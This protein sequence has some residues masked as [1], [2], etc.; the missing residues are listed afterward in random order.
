MRQSSAIVRACAVAS[1]ALVMFS[2]LPTPV[3]LAQST[4]PLTPWRGFI[5]H[6]SATQTGGVPTTGVEVANR[7]ISGDGRFVVMQSL[8]QDLVAGDLTWSQDIFLRDR[9]TGTMTRVSVT[10]DGTD[11]DGF[12]E[13]AAISTNGRHVAFVSGATNLVPGDT[14]AT[15]DIFVRDLGRARTVRV[16]VATDGIQSDGSSYMPAISA[17]GRFVAFVSQASTLVPGQPLNAPMQVYLHDRDTDGNGIFDEASRTAT[18]LESVSTTGAVADNYTHHVRVSADGRFVLFESSATNLDAAGNPGASNHI[19]LRDRQAGTTKMIDRAVTGAPSI[20]GA[21]YRTADMS[22]DGRFITYS[23][24]S[25]DIVFMEGTWNSQVLRYDRQAD[26]PRTT[27]VTALPDGTLGNGYTFDTSVSADGRYVAFRSTSTN[28]ASPAQPEN[29]AGVFVR[30]MTTGAF[31]RVDVLNGGE[32]FDHSFPNAVSLSADGTAVAFM[33]NAMNAVDGAYTFGSQHTFVVTAF[34]VSATSASFPTGGGSGAIDVAAL[35]VSGWNA[36]SLDPWIVLT[37]GGG[38]AA[39]SRTVNFAVDSNPSPV[40]RHG[41]IRLGSI[42]VAIQQDG[43]GD[44]TPPVIAPIV[45]G[46]LSPSGWYTSDITVQWSVSDPDSEILGVGPGCVTSSFTSDFL[47]A[48]PTCEATSHGGTASVSVP[49]RRDTTPPSIA[50]SAPAPVY[51]RT[52]TAITPAFSCQDPSGHSGVATCQRTGGSGPLDT[53]TP[54]WHPFTVTAVDQAGNATSKTVEYLIGTGVCVPQAPGLKAWWRFN[55][56]MFDTVGRLQASPSHSGGFYENAVAGKGWTNNSTSNRLVTS[57]GL[58]LLM[59]SALTVS[60]WVKP[61]GFSGQSGTL[62][63]KPAHYRVARYP[64]GTLRWAFSHTTGYD[65]V[66]TGAVI[67]LNLWSHVTVTYDHGLVKSYLN[68]RLV[69]T[70]QLSGTLV[71][72]AH[73]YESLTI[74]GRNDVAATLLGTFDE[75]QIYDRAMGA[76]DVD[77]VARAGS[78][79][80]CVPNGSTLA[81]T[82]PPTIS[83]GSTFRATAVLRDDTGNPVPNRYVSLRSHVSPLGFTG[84]VSGTTNAAGE[85]TADLPVAASAA[86]GVYA[87]AAVAIFEGDAVYRESTGEASATLVGG[88]PAV[89]WPS[90]SAIVYGTPLSTTQLNAT[91]SVAGS[92]SYSPASGSILDAGTHTLGVTFTP[93]DLAHWAPTTAAVT[94]TVNK[95]TP[96]VTVAGGTF[97]Y[98]GQPHAGNGTATGVLGESLSPVQLLYN[99]TSGTPPIDAGAHTVRA[100]FAGSANY[101]A[102]GSADAPL[103]IGKAAP[104]MSLAAETVTYDG[105][106]HGASAAVVGIDNEPLSPVAIAY[107]GATAT[108]ID[109]GTYAVEARYEGSANYTPVTRTTTLTIVKAVPYLQWF[110]G[111]GSIVYGTPLGAAHFGA[112]ADVPGTFSYAPGDGTILNTGVHTLTATFTPA[113][114][115]NFTTASTTAT[116]VVTKASPTVTWP[117]PGSIVYGTALSAAQLNAT[118]NVSGTF[119]YTPAAGTVLAAGTHVLSV[120]FAPDDSANY[121]A[122]VGGAT[123][124]I[125]KAVPDLRWFPDPGSIVYGTPLGAA[126]FGATANV[127]G[128]FSY[129][130]GPGT[131]LDTGS[132]ALTATFTPADEVNYTTGSIAATVVVTRASPTI[133]WPDPASIVYGTALS[134]AQLTATADVPG[135]F[136]YTPAPGALL[137]AGTHALSVT[138]TPADS[139]NY[140]GSAM[141]QMLSVAKAPLSIAAN[142]AVKPFGAPL[143]PFS[144]T[145]AGLVNGDS[146]A[147]LGGVLTFATSA[148]STSPVGTYP[149]VPQG[150]SSPNY[151]VTFVAGTLTVVRAGTALAITA[152]PNA[153]GFNQPV[154]YTAAISVPAPGAGA[155]GGAVQFF[156]NGTLVG[157]APLVAGTASITTNGISAGTHS[158]SATYAG[159]ASFAASTAAT[160]LT[161]RASSTSSTTTLTSTRNPASPG[162]SVTFRASVSGP[163]GSVS[164][165]VEFY[166]GAELLGSAVISG[167]V[168]QLTTTTLA[169]GGHAIVARYLGNGSLPPSVSTPLAQTVDSQTKTSSTV[170]SISPSPA[171]LGTEVTMTAT[172][173]GGQGRAPG[174]VVLFMV[175]GQILGEVPTGQTGSVTATAVLRTSALPRGTHTV[176]VVYLGDSTFRASSRSTTLTVN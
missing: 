27:I 14:N 64:D 72:G 146:I 102:A 13:A 25:P 142:D 51:Y 34:S 155:P 8:S 45:T 128:T 57:D 48:S 29:S 2:V 16:S 165:A 138:F 17:T 108:P 65:W 1:L 5:D 69:H 136:T 104:V 158:I 53:T 54:G 79:T 19:Y 78:G 101:A 21:D 103:V 154:T 94:I 18:T 81:V 131:I 163:S 59:P 157:T 109:A 110:P 147:S 96:V 160:A 151:A 86:P 35:P 145:A 140:S 126:H 135:T 88:T 62:V 122:V 132:H 38:F 82:V 70:Q 105:Q 159:D 61:T 43:D 71:F 11:P 12:S 143:P 83:Y 115:V 164:G 133:T 55:S 171:A 166:D 52:G 3:G 32:G 93:D 141:G 137:P 22:D 168:A 4:P 77:A 68:G 107:N 130:P 125:V 40:V 111:P 116:V 26:E 20:W 124:S 56:S 92:F 90:P 167:G 60:L 127:P 74:G 156:D 66:N 50:I 121:A 98:N 33:S 106:P 162:Q 144:A 152:S 49:L 89:S 161:V 169:A 37:E 120:N 117:N 15:H 87:P 129:A 149:L 73:E 6:V 80:S 31:T 139:A 44:T 97:T 174:G 153:A 114:E 47:Y 118:A 172:V 95:A 170:V 173:T 24:Y 28:L 10:E 41:R 123:L 91:A 84:A 85:L 100:S 148:A 42:V 58:R 119:T 134:A 112:T 150:L 9:Q 30:D 63:T 99:G 46:T 23:S 76:S 7:A 176:V 113:D 75:V 175:N 36:V 39:G 67:P